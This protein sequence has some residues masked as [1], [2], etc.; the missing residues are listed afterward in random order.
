M[1]LVVIK[2][3]LKRFFLL[4]GYCKRCGKREVP[5]FKVS[6]DLWLNVTGAEHTETYCINCFDKM[7]RNKG[8]Y[9]VWGANP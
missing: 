3:I 4:D 2:N 7:A 8:I 5:V 1:I 9:I 6:D